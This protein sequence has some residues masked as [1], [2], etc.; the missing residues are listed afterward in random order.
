MFYAFEATV[1][2]GAISQRTGFKGRRA[3]TSGC[4][5]SSLCCSALESQRANSKNLSSCCFFSAVESWWVCGEET[6][7]E[8]NGQY[9]WSENKSCWCPYVVLQH[10]DSFLVLQIWKMLFSF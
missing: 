6:W 2:I 8:L 1:Q 10:F 5:Q 9:G 4:L 3:K 7:K